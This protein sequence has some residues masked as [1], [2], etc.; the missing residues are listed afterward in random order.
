MSIF[1]IMFLVVFA[2][3]LSLALKYGGRHSDLRGYP[4]LRIHRGRVLLNKG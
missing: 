2:V 4:D 1:K 3:A